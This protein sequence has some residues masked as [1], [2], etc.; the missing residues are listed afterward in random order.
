[1]DTNTTM[2]EFY[3]AS[4]QNMAYANGYIK[5]MMMDMHRDATSD[6]EGEA[7][8]HCIHVSNLFF[9]MRDYRDVGEISAGIYKVGKALAQG[10]TLTIEA[11]NG[12]NTNFALYADDESVME[13]T[14]RALLQMIFDY[15]KNNEL[16][17]SLENIK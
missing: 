1:M 16:C 9:F 8:R 11:I 15:S 4:N 13:S 12:H 2:N 3:A 17:L 14:D 10:Q 6:R 7:I 5:G